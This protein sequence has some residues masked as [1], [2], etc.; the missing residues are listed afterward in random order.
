MDRDQIMRQAV[1][2]ILRSLQ[3]L[4]LFTL[5]VAWP[6]ASFSQDQP[7]AKRRLL[8]LG[9]KPDSHPASTHEYMAGVKLIATLLER[10][11][12]IQT[13]VVQADSPWKDGPEL[14]DGADGV[15]VFLTEGARW[16]TE[17]A[18]R[19]KAFQRLAKRGGGLSTLHWGMGS[20]E[21]APVG[22]FTSLFGACHGGPDRKYKVVT[23]TIAPA[24]PHPIVSGIAAV[25]VR[26]EFYY[27][28]KRPAAEQARVIPLIHV[29]I[30]GTDEMV[31]WGAERTDGGRSFGFSGLHYHENW[32]LPEY[33]RLVLQGVLWT[34]G[35]SIPE[36]GLPVDVTDEDLALPAQTSR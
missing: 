16:V 21:A 13:I 8:L 35:R 1:R 15:V 36:Q 26:D 20:R 17:D 27:A 28:L 18:D 23:E 30:D 19:L 34:V 12:N 31:A 29:P 7:P 2:Y 4:L 24:G 32:K 10:S 9:Q 6:D 14:L 5:A 25:R 11:P 3:V 33:R 22:D